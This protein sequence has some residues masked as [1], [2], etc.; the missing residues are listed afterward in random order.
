MTCS[1]NSLLSFPPGVYEPKACSSE[2][3][4][5]VFGF[6]SSLIEILALGLQTYNRSRYRQLVKRIGHIIRS[7]HIEAEHIEIQSLTLQIYDVVSSL[8]PQNDSVLCQWSLGRIC[9][10]KWCWWVWLT[11]SVF[12]Q[13]AAGIWPSLPQSCFACT[14]EQK[15]RNWPQVSIL[16][17]NVSLCT[18]I[19]CMPLTGWAFGCLCPRCHMGP[20]PALCFGGFSMLCSVQRRQDCKPS[21]PVMTHPPAFR[22]LKVPV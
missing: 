14:Q 8:S 4:M 16:T 12:G 10:F 22:L 5:R 21:A 18:L 1:M 9:A 2:K 6:A 13:T 3:M 19:I 11:H 7:E 17:R 20:C 15:V